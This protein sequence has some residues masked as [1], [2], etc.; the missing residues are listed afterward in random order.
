MDIKDRENK[1]SI[2]ELVEVG[3][4]LH[5]TD[6]AV[7]F[8][9]KTIDGDKNSTLC[10]VKGKSEK[11]SRMLFETLIK[12]ERVSELLIEASAKAAVYKLEQ[13]VG[14]FKEDK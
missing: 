6:C 9:N 1:L 11:I 8:V 7:I 4:Y 13:A 2:E 3:D 12:D 5:D 10:C 14:R